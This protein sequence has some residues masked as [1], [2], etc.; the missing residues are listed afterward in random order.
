M[1][2]F[3]WLLRREGSQRE[4]ADTETILDELVV[5]GY[6][7]VR[8]DAFPHLVAADRAGR[9][10]QVFAVHP[11]PEH[12]MWGPHGHKVEV[13]DPMDALAA[14]LAAAADR[15]VDVGLSSWFN[16]DDEH[17]R[18]GIAS[19]ADLVRVWTRTLDQLE[20]R[21]LLGGVAYVDL[22]NEFPG[23]DWLP[24]AN[25][26]IFGRYCDAGPNTPEQAPPDGWVWSPA[27]RA[28]IG[29]FYGAARLLKERWPEI[30]FTF[31]TAPLSQS[32]FDLD[33]RPLDLIE[34]H[35]WLSWNVAPFAELTNFSLDQH[36][37]PG[38]W[39]LQVDSLDRV[40]WPDPARWHERLG[41]AM[42]GWAALAAAQNR[43]LWTTEGWS[44]VFLDDLVSPAGRH[45][46]EY[47]K[48]VAEYAVPT[49]CE[50][51]WAGVC[52]SNFSQPHF[53]KLWADADWHRRMTDT[54]HAAG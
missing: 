40:Y 10:S 2:D 22:C 5:R 44:H 31:S 53:P 4:Y 43:P 20:R 45:A 24:A 7:C 51:G 12:F 49:A 28:R 3:S 15:E 25:E 34:T 36:G 19:P 32:V 8:I 9:S 54:I 38:A 27:Q 41:E 47:V 14:F 23:Y 37:F 39:Q 35:I 6:D 46:W 48:N 13:R 29:S 16:D 30:A 50:L 26:T 17:R 33:Y 42:R 1:W 52:T 11:Q 18:L 21:D